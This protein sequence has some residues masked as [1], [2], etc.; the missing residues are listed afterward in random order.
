MELYD[1]TRPLQPGM[2]VWPGDAA[3]RLEWT[4]RRDRG[5]DYNS[6]ALSLSSHAGTHADAPR[7]LE[8]RAAS[9]DAVSLRPYLGRAYLAEVRGTAPISARSLAHLDL[10][11]IERLLLKT[12]VGPPDYG[13]DGAY[14]PLTLEAADLLA[15]HGVLLV[16]VDAPS[17]DAATSAALEVHR[18]LLDR[19]IAILESLELSHVP[20][21]WYELLALPLK[22]IGVDSSPVRAVL[23]QLSAA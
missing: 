10:G 22:L 21:G 6:A 23:R 3:F 13:F 12:G 19:G 5:D 14:Q 18:R 17:V 20:E 7:H 2:A 9:I 16:G 8:E 11:R 1:V 15:R 4:A